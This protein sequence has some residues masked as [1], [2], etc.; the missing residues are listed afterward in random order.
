MNNKWRIFLFFSATWAF[1]STSYALDFL[2]A[3][4]MAEKSDPDILAAAFEYQSEQ[5]TRSQ[6]RSA[7]LP[8]V[9]L[10][11]LSIKVSDDSQPASTLGDYDSD[12][13]SLTLSQS[14]YNH[15]LYLKLDQADLSIASAAAD[16][17]AAAGTGS[18]GAG[19]G[20]SLR[21]S[22][23]LAAE[24]APKRRQLANRQNRRSERICS[25]IPPSAPQPLG[26][27]Q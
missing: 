23:W 18:T 4:E 6:S 8:Q 1:S 5:E 19:R 3:Y 27:P 13:Y 22:I 14:I 10:D 20:P 11:I 21:T 7:L 2:E 25:R 15:D 16:F 26:V 24:S 17:A 12:G 9:T